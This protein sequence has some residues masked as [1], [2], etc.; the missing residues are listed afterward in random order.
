MRGAAAA[1]HTVITSPHLDDAALSASAELGKGGATVVTVFAGLPPVDRPATW[2]DRLTGATGGSRA[3][4]LERLAED[5]EALRLLGA[6]SVH[7]DQLE[8]LHRDG[9]PEL[10]AIAAQLADHYAGADGIWLPAGIGGH[11]DHVL[12][13]DAGLRAAAA[14]GHREVVLYADFPYVISYGWPAAV[15][16]TAEPLLDADFWLADQIEAT[17]LDPA[18][19]TPMAV[20]LDAAQR[21]L[22]ARVAAAYRTQA[23][24]LGIGPRALAADPSKF[25]HELAWRT[26]VPTAA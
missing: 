24:A 21:V 18:A 8:E 16:G 14:T 22:K 9:P 20:T 5:S 26:A 15:S 17:G 11:Q 4:Q 3:R 10:D 6:K 12:T 2:W 25:D 1:V 7:L 13:R 23:P 19:L